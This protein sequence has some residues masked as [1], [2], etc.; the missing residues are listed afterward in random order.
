MQVKVDVMRQQIEA[1]ESELH[2]Q[3]T[4]RSR[5]KEAASWMRVEAARERERA[6]ARERALAAQAE[7]QIRTLRRHIASLQVPEV[8]GG[9]AGGKGRDADSNAMSGL[10]Q[11]ASFVEE[12][13]VH[14]D[15]RGRAGWRGGAGGEGAKADVVEDRGELESTGWEAIYRC[16]YV[17]RYTYIEREMPI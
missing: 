11:L 1:L 16:I 15:E 14:E 4:S 9:E 17:Y 6:R 2:Q 8:P 10:W 7:D 3:T 12:L 13:H 5:E